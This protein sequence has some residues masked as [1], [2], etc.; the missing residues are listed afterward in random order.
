MLVRVCL[1]IA[2]MVAA[3]ACCQV[4]PA[5]TGNAP[6]A[7]DDAPMQTPP[8]VSGDAFPTATGSETRSNYLRGGV[9]VETA[10][11]DNMLSSE[12][13]HPIGDTIL[14]I[15]PRI[16]LDQKTARLH[17]TL[18]YDP[19][20]TFYQH[21]SSYNE[22][23][24]N[25]SANIQYRVS[26]HTSVH[27][28]ESFQDSSNVFDQPFAYSG[29][30]GAG[31]PQAPPDGAIAPFADRLNNSASGEASV[32]FSARSMVGGGGS[33]TKLTYRNLGEVP[34]LCDSNSRG[35]SAFYN[36]RVSGSQYAGGTYQYSSYVSCPTDS[37]SE[38]KT[39]AFNLYYTLYLSRTFSISLSGGPQHYAVTQVPFAEASSWTPSVTA[40]VGWQGSRSSFAASYSRTVNGGGG[41]L[42]AYH[43]NSADA[44]GR[45]Q[46]T[47]AWAAE[48]AGNY[49]VHKNVNSLL[50]ET[51]P[52]GT[53]VSGT[54]AVQ[55]VMTDRVTVEMGYTRLHQGYSGIAVIAANPD[56][57]RGYVSV[58]YQFERPLG[59]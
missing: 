32:Q 31:L 15:R 49:E 2:L 6:E 27:L 23:D 36:L 53:T 55:R 33:S 8:P 59:R 9:N 30:A 51:N 25:A 48:S 58:S 57:D 50:T 41:L 28:R 16:E 11:D 45:W 14:S 43:S 47:R 10:Y 38:T 56:S 4:A 24:E 34:G 5:A 1:G 44:H 39:Q 20:F 7:E 37:E 46:M 29:G 42:G 52:G 12:G 17:Q 35:G 19:G 22:A 21:T 54:I 18:T 40:G 3:P 26:Q 13:T